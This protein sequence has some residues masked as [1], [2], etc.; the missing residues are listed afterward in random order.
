ML[1]EQ[2]ARDIAGRAV[3]RLGGF[4]ALEGLY[5]EQPEAYPDQELVVEDQRVIVRLRGR[6]RP[7]TIDV[8][9]YTFEIRNDNLVRATGT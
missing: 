2:D 9:P 1:S 8:G 3:E 5:Q 7:A 4:D 6:D